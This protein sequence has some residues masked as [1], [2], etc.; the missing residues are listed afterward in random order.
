A[1]GAEKDETMC[2]AYGA[3]KPSSAGF[4]AALR[5]GGCG[6]GARVEQMARDLR[7]GD[8]E[9]APEAALQALI[10]L[11][12]AED[13]ANQVAECGRIVEQLDHARGDG[14]AEKSS[15]EYLARDIGREFQVAGKGGAKAFGVCLGL[16][17]DQRLRQ[18][19]AG[20]Q[21]IVKP[22]AGDGIDAGRGVA[23]HS[24]ISSHDAA[25]ADR[26]RLGRRQHVAEET[27]AVHGNLFLLDEVGKVAAEFLA[28][29]LSHAG[30][31]AD[32]KMVGARE[33]P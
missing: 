29:G 3:T 22:L 30:A 32:G 10:I 9:L 23:G 26:L 1:E 25:T 7:N 20:A 14:A 2:C 5:A 33:G 19:V 21:R 24:P 8:A 28:G 6:D 18:Q 31:N 15:A 12:T 27:R 13:V 4:A 11:R 17:F 16:I